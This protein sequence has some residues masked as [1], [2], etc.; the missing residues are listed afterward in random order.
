MPLI[1]PVFYMFSVYATNRAPADY[2]SNI[3]RLVTGGYCNFS[4]YICSDI[5][6]YLLHKLNAIIVR[7]ATTTVFN[8]NLESN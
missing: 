5:L 3:S 4:R 7:I 8:A 1:R 6:F 2:D